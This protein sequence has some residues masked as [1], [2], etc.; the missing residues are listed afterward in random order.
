MSI[1][2]RKCKFHAWKLDAIHFECILLAQCSLRLRDKN[3]CEQ[4]KH[5]N[6]AVL[7]QENVENALLYRDHV[8]NFNF[9]EQRFS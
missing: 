4:C 6:F 7:Q 3:E 2:Q 1:L 5:W 8:F 9:T